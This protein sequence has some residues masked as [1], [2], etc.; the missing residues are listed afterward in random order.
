MPFGLTNTPAPSQ[1]LV[2]D[3]LCDMRNQLVLVYL[4]Y[5]LIF[6]ETEEEHIQHVRLVLRHLLENSL[7][8]KIE[9]SEFNVSS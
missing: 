5:I 9:K 2:N 1:A 7:F 6:S 8:V 4:D 3:V